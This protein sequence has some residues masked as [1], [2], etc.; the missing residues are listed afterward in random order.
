VFLLIFASLTDI[1]DGVLARK[2][3]V[4]F[5]GKVLD[6]TADKILVYSI[7]LPLTMWGKIPLWVLWVFLGRD[8][9]VTSLRIVAVEEKKD[10]SADW[11][12]KG[13]TILQFIALPLLLWETDLWFFS[14]S[15]LGEIFL[16]LSLILS[17]LSGARYFVVYFPKNG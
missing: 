12:G 17:C 9:L 13:K 8:F 14:P 6:P 3:G 5:L 11:G 15:L 7:L 16:Y 2:M 1:W 10:I 4:T